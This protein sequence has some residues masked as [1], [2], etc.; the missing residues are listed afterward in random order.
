V[1]FDQT[2]GKTTT[3]LIRSGAD[4]V[5]AAVPLSHLK[6]LTLH[7]H[8]RTRTNRTGENIGGQV[9]AQ[10]SDEARHDADAATHKLV[11]D[12]TERNGSPQPPAPV[13]L[14]ADSSLNHALRRAL[15]GYEPWIP[16][17]SALCLLDDSKPLLQLAMYTGTNKDQQRQLL[18]SSVMGVL[19]GLV[20]APP[21]L[22]YIHGLFMK[23]KT[24]AMP[25]E[26]LMRCFGGAHPEPDPEQGWGVSSTKQRVG[27]GVNR[28][29]PLTGQYERKE[30]EKLA[31]HTYKCAQGCMVH[32]A[33]NLG[34]VDHNLPPVHQGN[35]GGFHFCSF[36]PRT[37]HKLTVALGK[38]PA[39]KMKPPARRGKKKSNGKSLSQPLTSPHR[40]PLAASMSMS[41][42]AASPGILSSPTSQARPQ[43]DS[44][45]SY[46]SP[47]SEASEAEWRIVRIDLSSF[48]TDI[49]MV[50][51]TFN[52][53][54]FVVTIE[55]V[56]DFNIT[57]GETV[58][59]P[60]AASL[61][62]SRQQRVISHDFGFDGACWASK[63]VYDFLHLYLFV[64][65]PPPSYAGKTLSGPR[66]P[67]PPRA[68]KFS[69]VG[70]FGNTDMGN[71]RRA[72]ASTA[73]PD[74]DETLLRDIACP[75]KFVQTVYAEAELKYVPTKVQLR[76][77][78]LAVS[79]RELVEAQAEAQAD[80]TKIAEAQ[81][82]A[83]ADRTKI[84]DRKAEE[85]A[86]LAVELVLTGKRKRAP[87]SSSLTLSVEPTSSGNES[88]ERPLSLLQENRAKRKKATKSSKRKRK[89]ATKSSKGK[90]SGG[91]MGSKVTKPKARATE[92]GPRPEFDLVEAGLV[93]HVGHYLLGYN[94][95]LGEEACCHETAE[96]AYKFF[97]KHGGG[98]ITRVTTGT[99]V[100][101]EVRHTRV[102][103]PS[104]SHEDSFVAPA[105]EKSTSASDG[106][107]H[108]FL[109]LLRLPLL[110]RS[111]LTSL[112]HALG[113]FH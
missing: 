43:Q 104:G 16:T 107:K 36:I 25:N 30:A 10:K 93:L 18:D 89:K 96:E 42:F 49:K 68:V 78:K 22:D 11:T 110:F 44:R 86:A 113:G 9:A 2:R 83:Q 70:A 97:I 87:S 29:Q 73:D 8:L 34:N 6:E 15:K 41:P 58:L 19:L 52:T 76:D 40:T 5:E 27:N 3:Y 74:H 85:V 54:V 31:V 81:A 14:L 26:V 60:D 55:V 56:H 57:F 59:I 90:I 102:P 45:V 13:A 33:D 62:Q 91:V 66:G 37:P 105:A 7:D 80:W 99:H 77:N 24:H 4:G 53:G 23:S 61:P 95:K 82:E 32:R 84:A 46:T 38:L 64:L 98:G 79:M 48:A 101:W 20:T 72:P 69:T 71:G 17:V 92:L 67:R 63:L 100:A 21:G 108:A 50:S 65:K 28:V 51:G 106:T 109:L 47:C 112:I 12:L 111:P 75:V 88:D 39:I 94:P 103:Q 35:W 1:A